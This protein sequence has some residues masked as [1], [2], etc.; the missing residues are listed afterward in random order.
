MA[1]QIRRGLSSE[2]TS[3]VTLALA[4]PVFTLD[5]LKLYIGDGTTTADLLSPL[6]IEPSIGT[7]TDVNQNA[8]PV[9]ASVLR[10]NITTS[11]W[12]AGSIG[13]VNLFDVADN[14]SPQQGDVLVYN[15]FRYEPQS[16]LGSQGA[17][18]TLSDVNIQGIQSGDKLVYGNGVWTNIAD[19]L[20]GLTNVLASEIDG[21]FLYYDGLSQ[22]WTSQPLDNLIPL[23][24]LNGV[25]LFNPGANEALVYNGFNW[26]N[27]P[28]TSNNLAGLIDVS[29]LNAASG[30][31]LI[32]D[33]NQQL[34]QNVPANQFNTLGSVTDVTI[35]N[36]QSGDV[37]YYNTFSQQWENNA[38]LGGT[39]LGLNGLTDVTVNNPAVGETLI[40]DNNTG[41]FINQAI[42]GGS[43]SGLVDTNISNINNGDILVYNSTQQLWQNQ[44]SAASVGL[45]SRA[46]SSTLT[47]SNIA[48]GATGTGAIA[49][50][51]SYLFLK[52]EATYDFW[53]TFYTDA[54]SRSADSSRTLGTDPLAGSGV[55]AE[56]VTAGYQSSPV[57]I[58]MTPTVFGFNNDSTPGDNVYVKV[59]NLAQTTQTCDVTVTYLRLEA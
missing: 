56:I 20:N 47:M 14:I 23:D 2:L 48:S 40:Y 12:E 11:L 22:R 57:T 4:E 28:L 35:T 18:S 42:P 49:L 29:L 10:Y 54:A 50:A 5:T 26:T 15:G 24:E 3:S 16:P 58:L 17:I 38:S 25:S 33:A 7:C 39:V 41:N 31:T 9:D 36:P 43:V 21:Y 32:Y 53:I 27:T 51:K 44:A 30:D 1:L 45:Q 19:N 37:L 59:E 34:W 55:I 13:T 8:T 46:T 52:V 6:N